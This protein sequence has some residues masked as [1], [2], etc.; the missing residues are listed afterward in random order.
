MSEI[1]SKM[2]IGLHVKCRLFLSDFSKTWI[3]STDFRKIPKYQ[4][5]YKF[6]Q[7]DPSCSMRTDRQDEV[8]GHFCNFFFR[9]SHNGCEAHG[10]YAV[11]P[12]S[13]GA[14]LT[15]QLYLLP[16]LRLSWTLYIWS[17]Y[18]SHEV[19]CFYGFSVYHIPPCSFG[20]FFIIVY[21]VVCFVYFCLI[22]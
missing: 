16:K 5:S 10:D 17:P 21:M 15:S 11:T 3:F 18:R 13:R 7:W 4:I 1:W 22:L 9:R 8:N 12:G 14:N 6:V 20:S 19:C 2:Y